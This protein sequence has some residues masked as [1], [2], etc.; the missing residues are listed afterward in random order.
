MEEYR[1]YAIGHDGHIVRSAP[2]VC[3]D[4]EK[5]FTEAVKILAGYTIELWSGVRFVT[6]LDLEG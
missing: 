6:R 3:E 2:L 5:A 1:A 4:D